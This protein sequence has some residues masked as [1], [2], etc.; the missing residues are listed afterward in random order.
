[1][2]CACGGEGFV[3]GAACWPCLVKLDYSPRQCDLMIEATARKIVTEQ[4][5]NRGLSITKHGE[6]RFISPQKRAKAP[7]PAPPRRSKR[8]APPPPPR[9]KR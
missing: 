3:D 5:P 2:P 9:R 7:P 8:R 4:I 6:L 1:M